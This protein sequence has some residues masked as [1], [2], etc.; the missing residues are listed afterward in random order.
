M[1]ESVRLLHARRDTPN[2]EECEAW[3]ENPE[4]YVETEIC[5][6]CPWGRD[7]DDPIV[8]KLFRYVGLMNAGCPIG[9]DELLDPEWIAL[10][11]IRDEQDIISRE[12]AEKKRS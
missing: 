3:D 8:Y 11:V 4:E 7:V 9:R 6:V 2:C 10:G 1:R 12:I 5:P